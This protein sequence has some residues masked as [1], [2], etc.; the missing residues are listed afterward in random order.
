M[1]KS[2][3]MKDVLGPHV[4]SQFLANKEQELREYAANVPGEYDKQVSEYEVKRYLPF[5]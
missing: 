4:F 3:L 2:A 5:L 1:D